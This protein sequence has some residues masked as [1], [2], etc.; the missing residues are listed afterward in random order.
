MSRTEERNWRTRDID[1]V[2]TLALLGLLN[3]EDATVADAVKDV[4]PV[5]AAVVDL[6]VE[7][8]RAG[9]RVHYFGAGSSGRIGVSDAAE[10]VPTFG[11]DPRAFIAHHAGGDRAILTAVEGA[12][13]DEDLGRKA[14]AGLTPADV[15]VGLS[16][17]G[18]TPWVG[19]ALRA[20]REAG[21]LTVLVSCNLAAPLAPLA[22]QAILVDTGPEA[23]AGSTRLKAATAQK[24]V[25]NALSTAAMVRLGRTYS[26]LMVG[27]NVRN[28]KLRRR[29]ITILMDASGA[30]EAACQDE[31]A[32]CDGDLR[33]ALLCLLSGLT[34]NQ[35]RPA[36]A[37][38]LG[39]V[40]VALA[41]IGS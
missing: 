5:L 40:R 9:G 20:A 29:Q 15:A 11:T 25:L 10:V 23:I 17:S 19:G 6:V 28:A 26:N 36:L 16:A 22:E 1:T 12:E 21:A 32:R 30:A 24:M 33:L 13:D 37:D 8:L 18:K 35:A 7:R 39:S 4:L 38:A 34:P 41:A 27:M 3:A 31:L 14:A 2:P